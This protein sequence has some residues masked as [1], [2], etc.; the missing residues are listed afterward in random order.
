MVMTSEEFL[1]HAPAAAF[2]VVDQ[3]DAILFTLVDGA[4]RAGCNAGRIEAM[5]A[6]P[7]QI[8]HEGVLE[9]AIDFLLDTLEI[10]VLRTLGEF[11]A[12]NLLPVRAPLDLFH[13]VAGDLRPRPGSRRGLPL[14]SGLQLDRK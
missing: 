2:L 11:A 13:A 5:L 10:V 8:H 4:R 3:D 1:A 14:R 9:L 6:Q 7:R 12:E